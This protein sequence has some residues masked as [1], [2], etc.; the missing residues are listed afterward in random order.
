MQSYLMCYCFFFLF[1]FVNELIEMEK[2]L[3]HRSITYSTFYL[4][5]IAKIYQKLTVI[6]CHM[7][8]C[9]SYISQ[10]VNILLFHSCVRCSKLFF[11]LISNGIKPKFYSEFQ[12]TYDELII[13]WFTYHDIG[14]I[15]LIWRFSLL[16][17]IYGLFNVMIW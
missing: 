17:L 13:L 12:I 5:F 10:A 6:L 2:K 7:W 4:H 16:R 8:I 11:T 14:L 15:M 3:C 1:D 9:Q